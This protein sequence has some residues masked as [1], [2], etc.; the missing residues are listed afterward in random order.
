MLGR[1]MNSPNWAKILNSKCQLYRYKIPLTSQS[2]LPKLL[3]TGTAQFP[4]LMG[5]KVSQTHFT[6]TQWHASQP[7]L[8]RKSNTPNSFKKHN[9]WGS[10]SLSVH[11][12]LLL[13]KRAENTLLWSGFEGLWGPGDNGIVQFQSPEFRNFILVSL[14][15]KRLPVRYLYVRD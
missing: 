11:L 8:P 12:L 2:I 5:P 9:P 6:T 7:V 1:K 14:F 10:T 4:C 3:E 13:Y 15:R